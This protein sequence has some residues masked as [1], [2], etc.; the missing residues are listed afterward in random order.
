MISI[1]NKEVLKSTADSLLEST[2]ILNSNK[3]SV[4][5]VVNEIEKYWESTGESKKEVVAKI[6]EMSEKLQ[7]LV[8]CQNELGSS[9]VDYINI[10]DSISANEG[11]LK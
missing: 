1:K 8:A 7:G 6:K 5:W 2:A 11:G 10:I 4:N 3:E 9:I